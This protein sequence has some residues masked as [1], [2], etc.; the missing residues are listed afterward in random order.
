MNLSN[1]ITIGRILLSPVVAWLVYTAQW[2][3]AIASFLFVAL[4]DVIDGY[5]ARKRN[6]VDALGAFLDPFADKVFVILIFAALAAQFDLPWWYWSIISRDILVTGGALYGLAARV[7]WNFTASNGGKIVTLLQVITIG[8]IIVQAVAGT[9]F[10][11][12]LPIF[13]IITAI[14]GI[15]VATHYLFKA[16]ASLLQNRKRKRAS[17][18]T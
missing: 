16:K 4:S 3:L 9:A 2:P 14:S 5:I 18:K 13:V 6:E 15:M 17:A 10:G 7:P 12:F 8:L 11:I 1:S